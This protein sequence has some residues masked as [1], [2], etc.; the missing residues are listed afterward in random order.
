MIRAILLFFF[1]LIVYSALKVLFRSAIRGYQED[2]RRRTAVQG[3]EMVQDP[4]CRTYVV[5]S[6][7][8]TRRINGKLCS[9]CSEACAQQYEV[10]SRT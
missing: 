8:V 3:E 4:E 9:F 2:D 10:K 5:K 7:A 6:R 1:V